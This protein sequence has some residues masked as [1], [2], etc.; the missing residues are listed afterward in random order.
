MGGG[1]GGG[2][3]NVKPPVEEILTR[4]NVQGSDFEVSEH[5]D[6]DTAK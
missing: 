1:V 6:G 4:F 2:I 5:F 3:I